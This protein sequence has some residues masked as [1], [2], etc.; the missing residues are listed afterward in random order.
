M[1][2][3][4]AQSL[5]PDTV[6]LTGSNATLLGYQKFS[7][8]IFSTFAI[9][10]E[11]ARK[12]DKYFD[13]FGYATNELKIPNINNRPTWNYVKTLNCNIN[14]NIPQADLAEIKEIFNAGI[15][16]WHSTSNFKNY[17]ANNR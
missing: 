8:H 6:N 3:V 5:L 15:T 13:M 11:F 2:Q 10:P 12:I 7:Q 4:E 16:L 1:A 17:Y 14:G 9:K